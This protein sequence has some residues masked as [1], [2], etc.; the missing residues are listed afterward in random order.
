M[1]IPRSEA[2]EEEDEGGGDTPHLLFR[3]DAAGDSLGDAPPTDACAA[4]AYVPLPYTAGPGGRG[5]PVLLPPL[6]LYSGGVPGLPSAERPTPLFRAVGSP[7]ADAGEEDVGGVAPPH[8]RLVAGSAAPLR[9]SAVALDALGTVVLLHGGA[10]TGQLAGVFPTSLRVT[11]VGVWGPPALTPVDAVERIVEW[12]ESSGEER[13]PLPFT[14]AECGDNPAAI[15]RGCALSADAAFDGEGGE[16]LLRVSSFAPGSAP[17]GDD[18]DEDTTSRLATGW[19]SLQVLE[20]LL[21]GGEGRAAECAGRAPPHVLCWLLMSVAARMTRFTPGTDEYARASAHNLAVLSQV[22]RFA[23]P[24]A[25]AAGGAPAQQLQDTVVASAV[26]LA[27]SVV[28]VRASAGDTPSLLRRVCALLTDTSPSQ[29]TPAT[30]CNTLL[31]LA[32]SALPTELAAAPPSTRVLVS[33][34]EA[35]A[36]VLREVAI[37]SVLLQLGSVGELAQA[38]SAVAA[39]ASAGA[40]AAGAL[41]LELASF[42]ADC[43]CVLRVAGAPPS[44][45]SIEAQLD[46]VMPGVPPPPPSAPLPL[47][48]AVLGLCGSLARLD[49]APGAGSERGVG[50]VPLAK[51]C[52]AALRSPRPAP[53]AGVKTTAVD[54][55]LTVGH[56]A[57]LVLL[58]QIAG[59]GG[60]KKDARLTVH[61]LEACGALLSGGGGGWPALLAGVG[62]L[63]GSPPPRPTPPPPPRG[64]PDHGI[65]DLQTGLVGS[66]MWI[67]HST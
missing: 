53:A 35:P 25:A 39:K 43:A 22:V 34:M 48:T 11:L 1:R 23:W 45:P 51:A 24:A 67:T 29:M 21:G 59:E 31:G 44:L 19:A 60:V 58:G 16:F 66:V 52:C 26:A 18:D 40:A 64:D 63:E 6:R 28:G 2:E 32:K 37:P 56:T 17:A 55:A 12:A 46:A 5:G 14:P 38:A 47:L 49:M 57:A 30:L 13:A 65:P 62:A 10:A 61:I 8:L 50:A 42:L 20:T 54:A 9:D 27:T 33:P 3:L 41:C 36:L 7:F 4:F 15:S